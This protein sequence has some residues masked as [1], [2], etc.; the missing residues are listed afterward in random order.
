MLLFIIVVVII[1]TF[2]IIIT[3]TILW[4]NIQLS[5]SPSPNFLRLQNAS[6]TI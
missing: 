6:F 4:T 5:F 2:I 3:I 1:I